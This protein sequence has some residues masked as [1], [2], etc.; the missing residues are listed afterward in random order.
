MIFYRPLS[1]FVVVCQVVAAAQASVVPQTHFRIQYKNS[2]WGTNKV[3]LKKAFMW[4]SATHCPTH[5]HVCD[6]LAV[7]GVC[8][9]NKK[10]RI[11]ITTKNLHLPI[12]NLPKKIR[13]P[14]PLPITLPF[15]TSQKTLTGILHP[16]L[17]RPRLAAWHYHQHCQAPLTGSFDWL[18]VV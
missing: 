10:T 8:P 6:L 7:P 4:T 11:T 14:D 17:T 2:A 3:E 12:T 1:A 13:K 9:K 15:T 16:C 18:G 5:Q